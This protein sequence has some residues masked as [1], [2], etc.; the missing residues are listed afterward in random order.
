MVDTMSYLPFRTR[1]CNRHSI[2][3]SRILTARSE[4]QAG[5]LPTQNLG[6]SWFHERES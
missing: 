2:L 3:F 6:S 5:N 1:D 4:F